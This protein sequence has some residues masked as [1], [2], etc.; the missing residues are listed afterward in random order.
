MRR[1]LWGNIY[2]DQETRKFSKTP[3]KSV[4]DDDESQLPRSFVHF[5][6]TPLYKIFMRSMCA[7][8]AELL[9]LLKEEFLVD[10]ASLDKRALD[11][12]VKPLL[13]LVL[14]KAFPRCVSN[15]VDACVASL[16]TA[17]Q[18]IPDYVSRNYLKNRE[19]SDKEECRALARAIAQG[20]IKGPLC[21]DVL[22]QYYDERRQ[23]FDVYARVVSGTI[24]QG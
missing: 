20:N 12:D 22:K 23:R 2:Y 6:L 8:P 4:T 1:F 11:S 18:A 15:L 5:V 17:A 19:Q 13:N 21:V 9:R 16:Q 24:C 14:K 7:E 3:A 10:T